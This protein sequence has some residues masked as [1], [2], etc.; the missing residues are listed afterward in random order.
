ML[1]LLWLA[2]SGGT[3]LFALL[4]LMAGLQPGSALVLALLVMA[5]IASLATR[6]K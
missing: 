6:G 1:A 5:T 2:A 4:F 3:L